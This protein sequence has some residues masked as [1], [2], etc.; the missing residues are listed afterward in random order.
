MP[1]RYLFQGDRSLPALLGNE[2]ATGMK[3]AA[4][5]EISWV[6]NNARD[7]IEPRFLPA[8]LGP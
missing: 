1:G 3:A 2:R 7:Y 5:G 6:G 8:Q 4:L